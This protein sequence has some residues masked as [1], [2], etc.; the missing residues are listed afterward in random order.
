[1]GIYYSILAYI[2]IAQGNWENHPGVILVESLDRF[3]FGFVFII[4]SIGLSRLFL[5]ESSFLKN[6]E[7]PWLKLTDFY[8]L[9]T[10]LI[11]AILV[12][13]FVAW[14]PVAI[15]ITQHKEAIDWTTLIFPASLLMLAIAGKFIKELH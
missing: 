9:K 2:D 11:S 5:S 3:L 12:A 6:Y 15:A 1:L 14:A 10:L 4:F 13:L 8:Q 7:L